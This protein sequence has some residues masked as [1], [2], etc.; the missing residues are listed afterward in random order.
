MCPPHPSNQSILKEINPTLKI[1]WKDWSWS[2][3]TLAAWCKELTHW[4]RP[5]CWERL[6]AGGEGDDRGWDG[7]TASLTWWTWV[8]ANSGRWWRTG[9]LDVLL[10]TGSQRLRHNWV[11]EKQQQFSEMFKAVITL[12]FRQG[13]KSWMNVTYQRLYRKRITESELKIRLSQKGFLLG[14]LLK[15]ILTWNLHLSVQLLTLQTK[16]VFLFVFLFLNVLPWI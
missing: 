14:C 6:K 5:W 16:H 15:S 1:H 7:W 2:A 12:V 13:N 3:N 9:E 10:S 4:K 11:T 8:W